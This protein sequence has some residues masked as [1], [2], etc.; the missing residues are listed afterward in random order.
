MSKYERTLAWLKSKW[1]PGMTAADLAKAAY[2]SRSAITRY[3]ERLK[4]DGYPLRGTCGFPKPG[5]PDFERAMDELAAQVKP[6]EGSKSFYKRIGM[7][8]TTF[9]KVLPELTKRGVTFSCKRQ[10][11]EWRK[12]AAREKRRK[13]I[14][15]YNAGCSNTIIADKTG[16]SR[17]T[18]EDYTELYKRGEMTEDGRIVGK[19]KRKLGG[20]PEDQADQNAP[21]G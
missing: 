6:S 10:W 19:A 21:R 2:L 12:E 20:Q 7:C 1:E 18:V 14:A 4:E 15:L 9:Y 17:V 11:P 16:Y 8:K 13:V 5:T 3:R